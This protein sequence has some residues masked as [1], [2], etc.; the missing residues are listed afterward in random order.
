MSLAWKAMLPLGLVNLVA[1]AAVTEYA[2]RTTQGLAIAA[3]I[4]WGVAMLALATAA[5]AAPVG[6]DNRPQR[7]DAFH[8]L[9]WQATPEVEP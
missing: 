2:P 6:P 4:G 3:A 5:L 9:S 1:V 8:P 7:D